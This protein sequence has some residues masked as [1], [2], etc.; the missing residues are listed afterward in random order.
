MLESWNLPT[1]A[2]FLS[3]IEIL[4]EFNFIS[5]TKV[6]VIYMNCGVLY[7]GWFTYNELEGEN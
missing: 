2:I 6:S 5:K 3:S 1:I 7:M 4:G